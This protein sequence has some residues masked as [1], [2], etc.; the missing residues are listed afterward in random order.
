MKLRIGC[1]GLGFDIFYR[2]MTMDPHKSLKSEI[3]DKIKSRNA[4]YILA[5]LHWTKSEIG[6]S[7]HV[8][9]SSFT[10]SGYQITDFLIHLGFDRGFCSFAEHQECYVSCVDQ[11]FDLNNFI[12]LFEDSYIN[13]QE[14]Q[15]Y[16]E[17]CGFFFDRPEG[18]GYYFGRSS[19][20]ESFQNKL[21]MHGDGHFAAKSEKLK[22]SEDD[23]FWY[24]L[25]WINSNEEDKGWVIHYRP[26]RPPLSSEIKGVFNFL[27]INKFEQCP[28]FDFEP[29]GWRS[30]RYVQRGANYFDGNAD[31]AHNW[32]DSH[33]YNFSNGIRKLLFVNAEIEKAGMRFL[34]FRSAPIRLEEDFNKH[35]SKPQIKSEVEKNDPNF[36]DV[37]ISFAGR[38]R[39]YAEE[40][41]TKVRDAGFSVFYDDFYPENLWGKDLVV[42]FDEIYRKR[43]RFCVIFIS[44]EYNDQEWTIHERR[45]A[46]AR[47]LQEKGKEYILPIKVEDVELEG[48]PPTIG[49]L[50]LNKGIDQI[51]NLLIK[52]LKAK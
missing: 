41:A 39:K 38:D 33:A 7:L 4:N 48:M 21:G 19:G 40:L 13:L 23:I 36:F 2:E 50:S 3:I 47:A 45:S 42:T 51:A 8:L 17:K 12:N 25:S 43:S 6:F 52:K 29:C 26:K 28:Y 32:F 37:A 49:Y 10:Q 14:A 30:I 18:W 9:P 5:K 20:S 27:K 11:L 46:Q 44:K 34:P 15:K 1:L 22:N 16:L 35:V 31:I 24:V